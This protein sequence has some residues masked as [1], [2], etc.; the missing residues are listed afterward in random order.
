MYAEDTVLL[1]SH[2][3]EVE[4]EQAINHN[5]E[6]LQNW[7]CKNGLIL[8]PNKGKPEFM[9]FGT[10]AKR[11]KTAHQVEINI[12]SKCINNNDSYKYLGIH[13]DMS[14]NLNDHIATICKKVSSQ[15][16]LLRRI[17]ATLTTYA[18]M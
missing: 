17:R 3:N 11:S 5:A 8:N 16:G 10:A 12:G 2:K 15:L 1:F 9:L 6:L 14:L 13:L 18:T 7:L 4:K